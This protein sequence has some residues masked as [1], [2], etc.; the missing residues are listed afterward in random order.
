[1]LMT[2]ALSDS[3]FSQVIG[4]F[5]DQGNAYLYH[6]SLIVKGNFASNASGAAVFNVQGVAGL[7]CPGAAYN[8]YDISVEGGSYSVINTANN[9]CSQGATGNAIVSGSG[10]ISAIGAAPG[11]TSFI[12]Q[13]ANLP[14]FAGTLTTTTNTQDTLSSAVLGPSSQCFAQPANS[15]AAEMIVGTYVSGVD[16]GTATVTHPG[17]VAGGTFQV[18]CH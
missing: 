7:P 12:Q 13:S 16:W 5:L 8:T 14:Y 11:T 4:T 2:L 1:M 15:V 10:S 3:A 9:G 6:S 17:G 18:W